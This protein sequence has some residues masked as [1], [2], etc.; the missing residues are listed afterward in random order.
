MLGFGIEL[1]LGFGIG[2][3]NAKYIVRIFRLSVELALSSNPQENK[4]FVI[5]NLSHSTFLLNSCQ[6]AD[7]PSSPPPCL[8][9][10]S[11]PAATQCNTLTPAMTFVVS[12]SVFCTF[13][14]NY[15]NTHK[16]SFYMWVLR[17]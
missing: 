12:G 4:K 13:K 16:Y 5:P 2:R 1:G 9:N 11:K 8:L 14:I 17:Q 7:P 6:S 10:F 15:P 3:P